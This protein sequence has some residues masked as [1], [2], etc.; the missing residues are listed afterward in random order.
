MSEPADRLKAS[1]VDHYRIERELGAGGMARVYL[2]QDLKHDRQV[3][4][5]VLRCTTRARPTACSSTSCRTS[6]GCRFATSW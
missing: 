5:K 3:A 6:M 4:V 1:L 2:A